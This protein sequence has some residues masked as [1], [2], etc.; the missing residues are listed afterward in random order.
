MLSKLAFEGCTGVCQSKEEDP[1]R[2][3]DDKY[4]RREEGK[5]MGSSSLLPEQQEQRQELGYKGSGA[6]SGRA[7]RP[8]GAETFVWKLGKLRR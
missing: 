3:I 7:W 4:K 2:H 6:Q 1:S 5:R 8:G